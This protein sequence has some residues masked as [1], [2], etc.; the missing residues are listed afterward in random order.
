MSQQYLSCDED[1][2]STKVITSS[3]IAEPSTE[4]PA[5]SKISN[6]S[7]G[8]TTTNR[9]R[10]VIEDR[11]SLPSSIPALASPSPQVSPDDID[12][13]AADSSISETTPPTINGDTTR[14]HNPSSINLA[15]RHA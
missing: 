7:D 6:P 9:S 12:D 3:E 8:I 11:S 15:H 4:D 13:A 10:I 14:K 2:L 5:S 1:E